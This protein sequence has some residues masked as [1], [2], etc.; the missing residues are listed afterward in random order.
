MI[1][2]TLKEIKDNE[3]RVG[4]TPYGVRELVEEGHRVIVQEAAGLGSGFSDSEYKECGAEIM[5][6]PEDIV[7]EVEILVKVK[8]PVPSEYNLLEQFAGKTLFTY[9]HLSGVDKRLTK[10]LAKAGQFATQYL[11]LPG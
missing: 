6:N 5:R 7:R 3:N 10:L 2:G 8:E 4:L 1:I 11:W 9:L